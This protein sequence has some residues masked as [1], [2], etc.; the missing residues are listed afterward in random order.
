MF[1][2]RLE[3]LGVRCFPSTR[4]LQFIMTDG[5]VSGAAALTEK[6]GLTAFSCKVWLWLPEAWA[7]CSST[8]PNTDDVTGC[9]GIWR[10]VPVRSW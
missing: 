10:S 8:R 2:A 7:D 6:G 9:A 1:L 4:I 3:E 5:R